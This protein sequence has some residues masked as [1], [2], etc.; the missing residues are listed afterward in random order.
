MR[1]EIVEYFTYLTGLPPTEDQKKVLLNFVDMGIHRFL[2]SAGRQ[3]GKTL[4]T[5]VAICWW[6]FE[7]GE[8]VNILLLSAQDNILYLHIRDIFLKHP[9]LEELLSDASK[10]SPLLIPLHGFEL[11][12][13]CKVFV[14]GVTERNIRGI[15]ADIVI[16]DEASLVPTNS[17]MT[18]LGNITGRISK[19]VLL[20]TPDEQGKSI[21]NKWV[22]NAEKDGWVL[23]QWSAEDLPWH[24]VTIE[25][26]KKKEMSDA[27][28]AVDVLGRPPNKAERAYFTLK[29]L[30]EGAKIVVSREPN[31][32]GGAK[33]LVEIGIDPAANK[34]DG[35]FNFIVTEKL[36]SRRNVLYV[37]HHDIMTNEENLAELRRLV[38]IYRPT[39]IKMDSRPKEFKEYF[40]RA[41]S[42]IKF[43]DAALS[44]EVKDEEGNAT[45]TTVKEQMLGQLQRHI[46]M[47]TIEIPNCF[48]DLIIQLRRY[49][50]GMFH[51]DDLV[52]ALALSIYE[53][54]LA[55]GTGS[56]G[57]VY[58]PKQK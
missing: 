33:S 58:F 40:K 57:K 49:R 29:N 25:A 1:R 28:Y 20:S 36:G 15:P 10:L 32:Q 45:W 23:C 42:N 48:V 31:R 3:S 47:G 9:E 19:I 43:V 6:M 4:T 46:K 12:N 39:V 41:M 13:G 52:D 17:I 53:P 16:I 26:M 56:Y 34:Q 24:D 7:S 30:E 21:F 50:K 22:L 37:Q 55:W 27:L 8:I 35:G 18:A 38:N 54:V 2:I 14:R 5:A 11:K 44:E 51:G